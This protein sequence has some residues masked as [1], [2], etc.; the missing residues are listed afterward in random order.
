MK[1]LHRMRRLAV[2]LL[3]LFALQ[4]V[5][6]TTPSIE[7]HTAN[8][9][10]VQLH[11][12]QAGQGPDTPVIL[13]HGY[14]ETSHMWLPLIARLDDRRTVIAPACAVPA[15]RPCPPRATTRRPWR[16][17]STPWCNSWAITR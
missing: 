10:G 5:H 1:T 7:Q 15:I 4:A 9:N 6:A 8:A 17:T 11:Y 3:A 13:L 16:R 12:L 14:A 2:A